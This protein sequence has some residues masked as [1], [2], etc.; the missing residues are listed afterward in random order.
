MS[1]NPA[2][3]LDLAGYAREVRRALADLPSTRLDDLLEDLDE[4]LAEVAGEVDGPLETSLGPPAG[5]AA[6]LRRSAGLP[7]PVDVDRTG[8]IDELRD[9]LVRVSRHDAVR[10]VLAFLPE[11]RPAW[12]VLRG[13]LA[14]VA[15]GAL[16]GYRT[17]VLAFGVLLGPPLVAAAVVL[18]VRLGFAAACSQ[19]LPAAAAAH[20]G[21]RRR[22]TAGAVRTRGQHDCARAARAARAHRNGH[23]GRAACSGF[24]Q[25][26]A[27]ARPCAAEPV[28]ASSVSSQL[29]TIVVLGQ[30]PPGGPVS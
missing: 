26:Y 21:R 24:A 19:R 13:W 4:H 22:R 1:S 25:R 10:A 29:V 2:E 20:D 27:A 7:G 28:P 16:S 12:W 11:L 6:E 9:T 14:V 15:L 17:A 23:A 5:Y 3:P 8:R 18:S 30:A